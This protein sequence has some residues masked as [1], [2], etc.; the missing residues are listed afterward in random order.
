MAFLLKLFFT[1]NEIQVKFP[2]GFLKKLR[3]GINSKIHTE[4]K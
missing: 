2:G 3:N 1:F 4:M